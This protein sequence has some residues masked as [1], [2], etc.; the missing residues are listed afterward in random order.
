MNII[1]KPKSKMRTESSS[2]FKWLFVFMVSI[3]ISE[4]LSAQVAPRIRTTSNL[5]DANGAAVK[6]GVYNITF[7]M[8]YEESAGTV[9]WTEVAP[10]TVKGG[11]YTH[12][13]GSITPLSS[14]N[15]NFK[16][17]LGM[18]IGDFELTPRTELT[19]APYAVAAQQVVCSGAVGDVKY[20]LLNPA[21]FVTVNGD[22]WVPMDGGDITNS[23]LDNSFGI[24][25]APDG[26]GLFI[27]SQ[28]FITSTTTND[29]N[30][31]TTS[32]IATFQ[33]EEVIGHGH[34]INYQGSHHHTILDTKQQLTTA[35]TY[36]SVAQNGNYPVGGATYIEKLRTSGSSTT[37]ISV[38]NNTG[39]ETRPKNLNVWAYIRIN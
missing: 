1:L 38:G 30:R 24:S 31:T 10:V 13:L 37:G 28:E 29:P 17:F 32:A 25:T 39:P 4:Q 9:L 3:F 22:C 27:R 18:Q 11:I 15:F 6:D 21:Q 36:G 33:D 34:T 7:R 20:S 16:L 35:Y 2:I 5:K 23:K 19:Y 26:S 14:I 8:Y 12:L